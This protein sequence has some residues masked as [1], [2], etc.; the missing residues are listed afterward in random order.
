[1]L[2]ETEPGLWMGLGT[3]DV[4]QWFKTILQSE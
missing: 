4:G 3:P 1:M 2:S